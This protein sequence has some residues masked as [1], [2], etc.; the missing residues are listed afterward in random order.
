[1]AKRECDLGPST[2]PRGNEVPQDPVRGTEDSY[3]CTAA[4]IVLYEAGTQETT[5]TLTPVLHGHDDDV[6][7][8][9]PDGL[10]SDQIE[11]HR[12]LAECLDR[13]QRC[14]GGY[15]QVERGIG[16][17]GNAWNAWNSVRESRR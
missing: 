16:D 7:I 1:M 2:S 8:E 12:A 14:L 5:R 11:A 6:G 10:G 15:A 3:H 4:G 9:G 17:A 13:P